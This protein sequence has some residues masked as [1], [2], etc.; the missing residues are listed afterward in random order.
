LIAAGVAL[1]G[2]FAVA[3]DP[4]VDYAVGEPLSASALTVAFVDQNASPDLVATNT[5]NATVAV[6]LGAGDGTFGAKTEFPTGNLASDLTAADVGGDEGQDDIV[7]ANTASDTVSVLLNDGAGGFD[8]KVDIATGDGPNAVAAGFING[9]LAEDIAVTNVNDST[10]MVYL[11]VQSGLFALP[12]TYET[13]AEPRDVLL[14]N[15]V[16]QGALDLVVVNRGDSTVSVRPGDGLG[17][18]GDAATY[19][20]GVA[21]S[22]AAAGDFNE[23]GNNDLATADSVGNTVSVLLADGAGGFETG[24]AFP[25]GASP[26]SIVAVDVTDDAHEVDIAVTNETADK[27]SV[28]PGNGNGTLGN[29]V[30]FPTGEAPFSIVSGNFNSGF[31][32]DLATANFESGTVSVLLNSEEVEPPGDNDVEGVTLDAESPQRIGR[33]FKVK[34]TVSAAIEQIE[35]EGGGVVLSA[36]GPGRPD[37]FPLKLTQKTVGVGESQ[38]LNLKLQGSKKKVKKLTKQLKQTLANRG[39]VQANIVV[40]ASDAAGNELEF[41]RVINFE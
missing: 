12:V 33:T 31:L 25:A 14:E 29:P 6:R 15:V 4:K 8:P 13:G 35:A 22:A 26:R 11:G 3:F 20:T 27:V 40:V 19:A 23:D 36:S 41:E 37:V 28:L 7:T 9:D 24:N 2:G 32:R 5:N 38:A 10:V 1:A 34:T 30:A 21:P 18:F 16:G 17:G 39:R